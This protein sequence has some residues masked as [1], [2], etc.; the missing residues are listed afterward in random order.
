MLLHPS[1]SLHEGE[2]ELRDNDS[3]LHV[4]CY[5]KHPIASFFNFI[6]LKLINANKNVS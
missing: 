1:V 2:E 6:L 3:H 5:Y 4:Y